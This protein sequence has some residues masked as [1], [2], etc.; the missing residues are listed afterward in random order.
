M[1]VRL[2]KKRDVTE[3][4]YCQTISSGSSSRLLEQVEDQ[5]MRVR[6]AVYTTGDSCYHK[7]K[8]AEKT[9][10]WGGKRYDNS[11]TSNIYTHLGTYLE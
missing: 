6:K 5:G 3:S 7:E 8:G 11:P 10:G 4:R 9:L 1:S 2:K